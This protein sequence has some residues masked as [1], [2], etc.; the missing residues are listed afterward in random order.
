[1]NFIKEF[2]KRE[3]NF[4]VKSYSFQLGNNEDNL[5]K[6]IQTEEVKNLQKHI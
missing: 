6:L 1:M 4:G 5:V 2:S 3:K